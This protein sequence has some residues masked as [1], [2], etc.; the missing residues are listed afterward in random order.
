[1]IN[2]KITVFDYIKTVSPAQYKKHKVEK[3][4]EGM[5]KNHS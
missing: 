4:L 1:M 3:E 2:N 5:R